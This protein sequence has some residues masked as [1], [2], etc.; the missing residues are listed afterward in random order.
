MTFVISHLISDTIWHNEEY[1]FLI[2]VFLFGLNK[3]RKAI[4]ITYFFAP[5]LPPRIYICTPVYTYL[6]QLNCLNH[7]IDFPMYQDRNTEY[8]YIVFC[9]N[10]CIFTSSVT[11]LSTQM[12]QAVKAIRS[13]TNRICM[14][15]CH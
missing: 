2:R 6:F 3:H 9:I 8:V 13:R 15:R 11:S 7:I 10:D 1:S 12:Q 4:R 14:S 5:Y